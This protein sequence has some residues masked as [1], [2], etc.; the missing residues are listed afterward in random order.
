MRRNGC[1][2]DPS[3]FPLFPIGTVM[4]KEV[5]ISANCLKP[6]DIRAQPKSSGD[7]QVFD[8]SMACCLI[9]RPPTKNFPWISSAVCPFLALI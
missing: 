8:F 3:R 9:I 2:V 4:V 6:L 1:R 5:K 7:A